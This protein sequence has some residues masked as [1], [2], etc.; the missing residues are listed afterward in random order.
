MINKLLNYKLR[1]FR[2]INRFQSQDVSARL[3]RIYCPVYASLEQQMAVTQ[4]GTG[5]PLA[6]NVAIL[7]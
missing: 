1:E 6:T 3:K 7:S 4:I 5:V 2:W